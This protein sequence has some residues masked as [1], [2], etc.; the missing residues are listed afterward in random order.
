MSESEETHKYL[1][2]ELLKNKV[3]YYPADILERKAPCLKLTAREFTYQQKM[4]G[5]KNEDGKGGEKIIEMIFY[6]P[7]GITYS[8]SPSY[9]EGTAMLTSGAKTA[10]VMKVSS[11]MGV[12]AATSTEMSLMNLAYLG[13]DIASYLILNANKNFLQQ[14]E[15]YYK[16]FG[17][18]I[19]P[20]YIRYFDSPDTLKI[21][22]RYKIV[23][24]TLAEAM[25]MQTL[26][27]I[28]STI[29][30]SY[31]HNYKLS[32]LI[33][34]LV[35][36]LQKCAKNVGDLAELTALWL[37]ANTTQ[38]DSLIEKLTP[39]DN[40]QEKRENIDGAIKE[41]GDSL[42]ET[43][44]EWG[45]KAKKLADTKIVGELES[46]YGVNLDYIS[47]PA[48]FDLDI[49]GSSANA[50]TDTATVHPLFKD[51]KQMT[52]NSISITPIASQNSED[53]KF[54]GAGSLLPIGWTLEMEFE[55]VHKIVNNFQ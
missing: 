49:I 2:E 37:N 25:T 22:L 32:D 12:A 20:R 39:I 55:T 19:D 4:R 8:Y 15:E 9:A 54:V 43:I 17:W 42:Q 38:A 13:E 11:A 31:S 5:A 6:V 26:M 29:S 33:D 7:D 53:I 27:N 34:D 18:Y 36:Y 30:K 14:Y 52:I 51:F 47:P 21:S 35:K 45:E 41:A 50:R 3:F 23:P 1:S 48:I 24:Q 44:K 40:M 10:P 46:T 16:P 28:L